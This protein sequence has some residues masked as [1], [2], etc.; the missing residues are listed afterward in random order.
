[1]L[2]LLR[3]WFRLRGLLAPRSTGVRV[4][5]LFLKIRQL[6][7]TAPGAETLLKLS[8]LTHVQSERGDIAAYNWP[9][10]EQPRVLVLHGWSDSAGNMAP[11]IAHLLDAGFDV[12]AADMPGHGA[13]TSGKSNMGEYIRAIRYLGS[14]YGEWHAVV[15]HSLGACCAALS[16]QSD[17]AIGGEPVSTRKL[18]LFAPPNR[19]HDMVETFQRYMALSPAVIAAMEAELCRRV[20]EDY[21]Q[22]NTAD[23]LAAFTGK[24]LVIH[25]VDDRRVPVADFHA[26]HTRAPRHDYVETRGLGHRRILADPELL[27]R[28]T[29]FLASD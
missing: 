18:V 24:A 2:I 12:T 20:G 21:R 11:V 4:A 23:A 14:V 19:M 28:C 10:P 27:A 15:A 8:T 9:R 25:D 26:E 13:S 3:S 6:P 7:V 29:E 16:T 22:M 1:M 5:D 17:V